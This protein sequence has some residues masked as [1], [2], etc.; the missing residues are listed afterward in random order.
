MIN[1]KSPKDLTVSE[2]INLVE[3]R[4]HTAEPTNMNAWIN[5]LR[6]I[7]NEPAPDPFTLDQLAVFRELQRDGYLYAAKDWNGLMYV[8]RERPSRHGDNWEA[9]G[10]HLRIEFDFIDAIISHDDSEPLCFSDYAPINNE[11]NIW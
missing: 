5:T 7:A 4:Y 9:N 8:Y 6:M 10:G 3:K 1:P 11:I 2:F